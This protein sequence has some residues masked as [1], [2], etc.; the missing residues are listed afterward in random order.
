MPTIPHML[1][2]VPL[3]LLPLPES[4]GP[5]GKSSLLTA[6]DGELVRRDVLGD[7][8]TGTDDCS[9]ADAHRSDQRGV[10][11]N[12]GAGSDLRQIFAETVIIAGDRAG[13]N[14]GHFAD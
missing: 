9:G 1:F 4:G 7:D 8:R 2:P 6:G 13:S 3:R 12:E 5:A 11:T 14:V 10:R